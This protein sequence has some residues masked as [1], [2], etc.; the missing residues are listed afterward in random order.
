MQEPES[1]P[2][3]T[4]RTFPAMKVQVHIQANG[5]VVEEILIQRDQIPVAG[6]IMILPVWAEVRVIKVMSSKDHYPVVVV[7]PES[8]R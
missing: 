7:I 2:A 8:F 3:R 4:W 6:E 5:F 1:S